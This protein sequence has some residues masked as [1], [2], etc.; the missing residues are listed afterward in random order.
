[1]VQVN[2]KDVM[3]MNIRPHTINISPKQ[4]YITAENHCMSQKL[5]Y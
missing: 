4:A 3:N 2:K 5:Q 1:V